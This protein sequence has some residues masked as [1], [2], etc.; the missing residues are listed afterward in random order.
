MQDILWI[1]WGGAC[2]RSTTICSFLAINHIVLKSKYLRNTSLIYETLKALFAIRPSVLIVNSLRI[3]LFAIVVKRFFKFSLVVDCHYS[4]IIPCSFIGRA[5][6]FLYPYIYRKSGLILVTNDSHADVVCSH[7]GNSFV[8]Q[9]KIPTPFLGSKNLESLEVKKVVCICSYGNDEPISEMMA[10]ARN[11]MSDGV[12]LYFTGDISRMN[13]QINIPE[14]VM[15]TGYLPDNEYWQLLI[16]ANV[17]V[18]LTTREDCLVCGAYEAISLGKPVVLSNTAA[19]R[20]Y[21]TDSVLFADTSELSI[22]ENIR[23]ALNNE[24]QLSKQVACLKLKLDSEWI[25][26]GEQLEIMINNLKRL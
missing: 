1:E 24:I 16:K 21:F 19:L 25:P 15:F 9:D 23:F 12:K 6:H 5:F 14:N 13:E 8:I 26:R 10:A 22:A 18:D 11:L 3:A 20:S 4:G 2:R 7:G 17:I